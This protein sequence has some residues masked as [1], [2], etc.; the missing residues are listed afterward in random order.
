[1]VNILWEC[2]VLVIQRVKFLEFSFE[3]K[4]TNIYVNKEYVDFAIK[5]NKIAKLR[6]KNQEIYF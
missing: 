6:K 3:F 2:E 1:M 4:S 5:T